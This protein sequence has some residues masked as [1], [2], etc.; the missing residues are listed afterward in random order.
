[1]TP[2]QKLQIQEGTAGRVESMQ[3]SSATLKNQDVGIGLQKFVACSQPCLRCLLISVVFGMVSSL[4]PTSFLMIFILIFNVQ[5]CRYMLLLSHTIII[6]SFWTSTEVAPRCAR[7][8]MRTRAHI[9]AE[10]YT[11]VSVR[12]RRNYDNMAAY[13]TEIAAKTWIS[14]S[15]G[16]K[17][18]LY[19]KNHVRSILR[20]FYVKIMVCRSLNLAVGRLLKKKKKKKMENIAVWP[21]FVYP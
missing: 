15:K 3:Q 16:T 10:V 1:M 11:R 20:P 7:L 4:H 17:L 5:S 8:R 14:P 6:L 13:Y 18:L 21:I 19:G 2:C 9:I 12:T